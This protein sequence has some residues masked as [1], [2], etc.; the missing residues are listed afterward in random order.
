MVQV[1]SVSR[2][3]RR[4]VQVMQLGV[5]PYKEGSIIGCRIVI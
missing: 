2:D 1:N 4:T 3:L 5:N